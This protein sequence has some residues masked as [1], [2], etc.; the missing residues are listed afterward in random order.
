MKTQIIYEDKD[1]LVCYKPAGIA[2]QSANIA[3]QDMVSELKNYLATQGDKNPY[4]GVVHRLDRPTSGVVVFAKTSKALSRL[5]KIFKEDE[6]EIPARII[7]MQEFCF[8][9]QAGTVISVSQV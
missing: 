7:I 6:I 8:D 3:Q 1:V 4:I 2:V 9:L 5:N